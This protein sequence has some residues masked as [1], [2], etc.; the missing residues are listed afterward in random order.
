MKLVALIVALVL[1]VVAGSPAAAQPAPDRNCRDDR[2]ADRCGEEARAAMRALYGVPSIA[3]HR[4]A[5]DQVRRVFYVDG[6]G[7]DLLLISFVRAPG[8]DPTLFVHF[9]RRDGEPVPAPLSAPVPHHLW[10]EMLARSGRF[11]REIVPLTRDPD[12]LEICMHSW[13]YTIEATDP[14][15]ESV[16]SAGPRTEVEDACEDGLG[17]AFAWELQRMALPLLPHCAR[18]DPEQHRGPASQLAACRM[19]SGDRMAAAEVFNRLAA[20]REVRGADDSDEIA[21]IFEYDS[22]VIDWQGEVHRGTQAAAF[23]ARKIGETE[24]RLYYGS[25]E[26]LTARRARFAGVLERTRRIEGE[27]HEIHERAPVEMVWALTPAL[28]FQVEGATVGPWERY[29][30]D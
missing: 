7:R 9:P 13:V 27:E 14:E 24:A 2:G 25:V 29:S 5:G 6:Y 4:E 12:A 11:D 10:S 23:W 21:G 22:A 3:Q 8:R 15:H 19:L 1:A 16:R 17:E 30:Y 28:L 20:F 18:L 26:G